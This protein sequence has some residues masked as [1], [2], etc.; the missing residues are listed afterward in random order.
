MV[1]PA[2]TRSGRGRG[3]SSDSPVST[4]GRSRSR[5]RGRGGIARSAPEA[6]PVIPPLQVVAGN[7]VEGSASNAPPA[8]REGDEVDPSLLPLSFS[9]PP[10]SGRP[11]LVPSPGRLAPELNLPQS[12]TGRL[13]PETTPA[14]PAVETL[15]G[16]QTA[17][18]IEEL[19]MFCRQTA[20]EEV[21]MAVISLKGTYQDMQAALVAAT[22]PV[23][24]RQVTENLAQRVEQAVDEAIL[25]AARAQAVPDRGFA[26]SQK[27]K[28]RGSPSQRQQSREFESGMATR[29]TSAQATGDIPS[30]RTAAGH[31][32]SRRWLDLMKDSQREESRNLAEDEDR[33]IDYPGLK[34]IRPLNAHFARALSYKTYRL[35]KKEILSPCWRFSRITSSLVMRRVFLREPRYRS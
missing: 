15:A 34:E 19:K 23:V 5:G 1:S 22:V 30:A 20:R 4:R 2:R 17:M 13:Q 11:P 18:S 29:N 3:A 16:V 35:R 10:L 33:D 26:T 12:A 14:L 27:E 6:G 25:Q 21:S 31:E 9:F 7:P 28:D 32:Q 24:I 8:R